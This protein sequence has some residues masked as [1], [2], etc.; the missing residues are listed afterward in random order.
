MIWKRERW[1]ENEKWALDRNMTPFLESCYHA[2]S[3]FWEFSYGG[4]WG[5][6]EGEFDSMSVVCVWD[7]SAWG[8]WRRVCWSDWY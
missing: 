5:V 6:S 7:R 2:T 3:M 4:D 8:V 1:A